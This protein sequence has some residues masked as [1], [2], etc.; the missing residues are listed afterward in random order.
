M[1]VYFVGYLD[2]MK[3]EKHAVLKVTQK[4]KLFCSHS[5]CIMKW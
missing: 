1:E 5:V 4:Q 2:I 3:N